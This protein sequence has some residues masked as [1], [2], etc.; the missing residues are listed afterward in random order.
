METKD[1]EYYRGK[2]YFYSDKLEEVRKT[3]HADLDKDVFYEQ[4]NALTLAGNIHL[5][6]NELLKQLGIEGEKVK[7]SEMNS[8]ML[9]ELNRY[10]NANLKM[11][12]SALDKVKEKSNAI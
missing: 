5:Y 1:E 2:Y 6:L 12:W 7:P 11:V 8:T 9:D 4:M 10:L 3:S